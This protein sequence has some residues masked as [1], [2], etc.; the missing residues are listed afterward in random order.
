MLF[1]ELEFVL[2]PLLE[3]LLVLPELLADILPLRDI[4]PLVIFEFIEVPVLL[5][6]ELFPIDELFDIPEFPV[7]EL[8]PF[9]I[10]V[11]LFEA[12]F[13]FERLIFVFESFVQAPNIAV[14]TIKLLIAI[15]FFIFMFC[16]FS[17]FVINGNSFSND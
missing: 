2:V 17:V 9:V 13:E 6:D 7:I 3:V 8:F 5:I 12:G 4:F 16:V 15:I 14:V 1:V 11:E 10:V